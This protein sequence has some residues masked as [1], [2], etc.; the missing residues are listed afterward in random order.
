MTKK[1][2][3]APL[4]IDV[5]VPIGSYYLLKD[6]LGLSTLAALGWSSLV[7]AVRTGWSVVRERSVNVLAA[8]ILFVNVV[9]LPLSLVAG[10]PRLMLVKDSGVSSV[11]G[12]GVL[13]SVLL[14]RPAMTAGMKPWLVKGDPGREEAWLRLQGESAAFRRFERVFSLVWGVVL[15]GECVVRIVGAYTLPVDTMVWLGTV[16]MIVAMAAGFVVSGALAAGPMAAM[17]E[18]ELKCGGHK[19]RSDGIPER[20]PAVVGTVTT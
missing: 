17:L 9:G 2:A 18:A 11:V 19:G 6:G 15:L 10:D 13:V 12:I 3:F 20:A 4:L 1:K 8:L 16:I 7:P 14:G 5:A